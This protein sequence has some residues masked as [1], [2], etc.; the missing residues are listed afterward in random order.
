MSGT[1]IP[2][3]FSALGVRAPVRRHGSQQAVKA[4]DPLGMP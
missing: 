2:S 1:L 3:H 4:G